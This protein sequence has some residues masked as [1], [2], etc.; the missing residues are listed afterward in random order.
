M[1]HSFAM[2]G[3]SHC[4]LDAISREEW[5]EITLLVMPAVTSHF[6]LRAGDGSCWPNQPF[7]LLPNERLAGW[8]GLLAMAAI[9]SRSFPRG[10]GKAGM[11]GC[12]SS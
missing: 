6:F 9:T 10:R 4:S 1:R 11:G 12:I 3:M 2:L 5:D 7:P 8:F